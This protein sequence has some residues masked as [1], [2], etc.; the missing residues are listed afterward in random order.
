MRGR[1]RPCYYN[2]KPK[3]GSFFRYSRW[4]WLVAKVSVHRP[5]PA[6]LSCRS[7]RTNPS[8]AQYCCTSACPSVPRRVPEYF[9]SFLALLVLCARSLDP[10]L[11]PSL[12]NARRRTGLS[13]RAGKGA[14]ESGRTRCCCE[15][16]SLAAWIYRDSPSGFLFVSGHGE[17][18]HIPRNLVAITKPVGC[19]KRASGRTHLLF[20]TGG[21]AHTHSATTSLQA[22]GWG[23]RRGQDNG[24]VG[25][26]EPTCLKPV[27]QCCQKCPQNAHR[28]GFLLPLRWP[29]A[30]AQWLGDRSTVVMHSMCIF[31]GLRQTRAAADPPLCVR[32]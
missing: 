8:T 16:E 7:V 27:C 1:S 10:L 19:G 32:S 4:T 13:C 29:P 25:R 26:R 24:V 12:P 3:P 30:R 22:C 15:L 11:H 17:P 28:T 23:P 21:G 9:W 18:G 2:F 31:T 14:Q 5:T 20:P 6:R